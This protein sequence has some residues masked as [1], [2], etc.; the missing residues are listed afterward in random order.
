MTDIDRL[1]R[2]K[3]CLDKLVNGINPIDGTRLPDDELLRDP[4]ISGHLKTAAGALSRAIEYGFNYDRPKKQPFSITEEQRKRVQYSPKPVTVSE[5]AR[6]INS[7]AEIPENGS[8]L[9][10]SCISFWLIESGYLTLLKISE[11]DDIKVPTEEGRKIGITTQKRNGMNGEYDV[12]VYEEPAQR[13]IV[14]HVDDIVASESLRFQM[15]G[16]VWSE[17]EEVLLL[18][19]MENDVPIYEIALKLRRNVASVR[20]R[21]RKLGIP[22]PGDREYGTYYSGAKNK[23]Y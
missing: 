2:A 14:E 17:E 6:R 4:I 12:I 1:R 15:Q 13:F 22:L 9:R 19:A 23:D 3:A 21:C 5:L 10:Y 8:Q 7:A 16:K 11:D 18:K 20:S